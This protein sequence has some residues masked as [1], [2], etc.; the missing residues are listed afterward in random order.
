MP[1]VR[2][3]VRENCGL[4]DTA[5]ALVERELARLLG[6]P[7][8]QFAPCTCGPSSVVR[9]VEYSDGSVLQ[10]IDIDAEPELKSAFGFEIPVVE[11]VGG[12]SFALEVDAREFGAAIKSGGRGVRA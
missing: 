5:L 9:R 7:R 3:F 8:L 6:P 11:V 2:V 10:V 12:R 1:D 4:C